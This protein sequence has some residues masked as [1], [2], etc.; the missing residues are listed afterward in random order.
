MTVPKGGSVITQKGPT[1]TVQVD[2]QPA[3][4]DK[5]YS[6]S[7]VDPIGRSEV[8]IYGPPG[9]G[10]T[11][12][13][14]TFPGPFRWLDADGGLKSVRWAFSAGKTSFKSLDDLVAYRP[15]EV[16]EGAYPLLPQ[17]LDKACDMMAYWFSD[18][19][20]GK[21]NTLV[22]DSATEVNLWAI[23]KA[24]HLNG[25]FPNKNRPLSVSDDINKQAKAML[26]TGQQDYKSAMGLFSGVLT[27]T[28]ILCAKHGKNFVLICH[29]WTDEN[30]DGQ[31]LSYRPLLIGQ[32]RDRVAK[33]FD[34]V[35]YCRIYKGAK[36][37][38][39]KLQVH[40]DPRHVAKTRWGQV[41]KDEEEPDYQALVAKVKQFHNLP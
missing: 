23:Y 31:V 15:A 6:L 21:W 33:D 9:G 25:R 38:E 12:T 16:L 36:G 4:V 26:L 14:A 3:E 8:L 28:R 34:D 29:E 35:W 5:Q 37:S 19:E 13:A 22:W 39:V 18:A 17:A 32:L 30:E 41:L 20:V 40:G 24:L 7:K 10:K 1:P 2:N 11:V 27:D